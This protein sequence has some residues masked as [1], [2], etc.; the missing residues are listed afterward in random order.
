MQADGTILI[1]TTISEDGFK[2]GSKDIELAA[3][4]M[5]KTVSDIGDKSKIALQKQLDSFSKLNAQYAAQEK[6]VE[7]LKKKIE[8]FNSQKIP[9]E[10]YAEIQKQ[11]AETEK[12]LAALN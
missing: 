11:I 12:K 5:A 10:E 8:E 7:A 4:R 2:A 6:R 1:D 9:T 3:K